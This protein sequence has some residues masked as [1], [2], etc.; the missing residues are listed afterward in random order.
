M[1]PSLFTRILMV[2]IISCWIPIIPPVIWPHSHLMVSIILS[3]S[4]A[5]PPA[6]CHVTTGHAP[7]TCPGP[8]RHVTMASVSRDIM[9][10]IMT[11]HSVLSCLSE[12]ETLSWMQIRRGE[13]CVKRNNS[14]ITHESWHQMVFRAQLSLK[15]WNWDPENHFSWGL[16]IKMLLVC[17]VSD[18]GDGICQEMINDLLIRPPRLDDC[19]MGI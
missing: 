7:D 2:A 4:E 12:L 17:R 15:G 1:I 14:G 10:W 5:V 9:W 19:L 11:T 6:P 3:H 8:R 13:S 16:M 18:R